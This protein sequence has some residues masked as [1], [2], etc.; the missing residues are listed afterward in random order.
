MLG[1]FKPIVIHRSLAKF[2]NHGFLRSNTYYIYSQIFIATDKY[3]AL[4]MSFLT[5]LKNMDC[6]PSFNTQDTSEHQFLHV[7][8]T[9]KNISLVPT[10]PLK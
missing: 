5:R 7:Y 3:T 2:I 10:E 9:I 1:F 8:H 6:P 4:K